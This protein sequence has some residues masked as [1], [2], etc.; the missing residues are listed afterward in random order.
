MQAVRARLPEQFGVLPKANVTI[1]RVPKYIESSA[2]GGYYQPPALDGSRPGRYYINL[3]DT[4][5]VPSWTLPTLTFHE[6]IPG[7]H[8]QGSIQ[9][10]ANLPLIRK[11]TGYTAYIEGWALYAEQL[12]VEMGMYADDSWGHIGQLHDAIFRGVRLVID[13]GMHSMK[14][15]REQAIKYYVDH[16]GDPEASA[17]TEV[18][19]YCVWPG[20]ACSYM[21]GKTTFLRLRDKAKLPW[22]RASIRTSSTTLFC[23]AAPCR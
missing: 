1:V 3:R 4:A 7:H 2:P 19:R 10:E 18:E 16:I 9:Q 14:W 12:A 11:I 20:Q 23:F 15:S 21:V 8:L 13:S 17:T 5:E 22:G 6:V